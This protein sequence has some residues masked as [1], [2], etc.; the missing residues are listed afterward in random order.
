MKGII[1]L[2][3]CPIEDIGFYVEMTKR[4]NQKL[5]L[6]KQAKRV[7]AP[8]ILKMPLQLDD[9]FLYAQ[10]VDVTTLLVSRLISI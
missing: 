9:I 2:S 6:K 1:S 3:K 4:E 7:S 5:K 10:R 8:T